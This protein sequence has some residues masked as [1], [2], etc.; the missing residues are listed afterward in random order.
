MDKLA[1]ITKKIIDFRNKRNWKKFHTTENLSKSISIEAG[2]LLEHFQWGDDYNNEEI[3]EELADILIYSIL[4]AESI[5]VN[6]F[7]IIEKKLI[8]NEKRFPVDRV[9]GTS[10]KNTKVIE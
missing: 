4:M 6:I 1:E 5:D 10:G 9:Y 2:E 7:D 3:S 8:K